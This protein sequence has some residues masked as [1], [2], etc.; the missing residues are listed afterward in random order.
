LVVVGMAERARFQAPIRRG[1]LIAD[2][3]QASRSAL[4]ALLERR[5]VV[6]CA[7]VEDAAGAIG[8]AERLRPDVCLLDVA[9]AGTAF[10]AVSAIRDAAPEVPVVIVS[11][12][13]HDAE[14]LQAVAAG[15]SG[16]L[17][18]TLPSRALVAA[19]TDVVAGGSAFP[20]R[21]E[22]LLLAALRARIPLSESDR[23]VAVARVTRGRRAR[24]SPG[25]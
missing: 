18:K 8:V 3:V 12:A 10:D 15:A 24:P 21:L 16:Y 23:L 17:A 5:E 4:R 14:G 6:V 19:L 2:S 11:A 13:P 22:T 7:D 9:I 20:R 25:A 1:V